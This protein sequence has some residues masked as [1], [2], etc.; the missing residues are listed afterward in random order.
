MPLIKK[1][2]EKDK[3][4]E[5]IKRIASGDERVF[6]QLYD[7]TH[8][9]VYFYLLRHLEGKDFAEDVL[10][11]TYAEVWRCAKDF[12]GTSRPLTWIMGIARNLAMNRL[13]KI[14]Y[15]DNID[16]CDHLISDCNGFQWKSIDRKKI[17]GEVLLSLSPKHREVLDLVFYHEMTCREVSDLLDIPVNTVKTR[18]FYAKDSMKKALKEIGVGA[19]DL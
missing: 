3:E 14:K 12:K 11:E 19:D 15:H 10:V 6:R 8:Q 17:L 4:P 7:D 16:D 1:R 18:L 5:I 9:Q 13:K 2:K